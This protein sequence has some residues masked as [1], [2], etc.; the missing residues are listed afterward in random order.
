MMCAAV[1][2]DIL[3]SLLVARIVYSGDFPIL[4]I[5]FG[6]STLLYIDAKG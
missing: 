2:V 1:H 5:C 3:G 4:A 6:G